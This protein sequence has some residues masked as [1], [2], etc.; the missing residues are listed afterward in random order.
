MNALERAIE[1]TK[2]AKKIA[3]EKEVNVVYYVPEGEWTYASVEI[4]T[5]DGEHYNIPLKS[6][7]IV[8]LDK[9]TVEFFK[10]IVEYEEGE[11]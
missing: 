11:E 3:K 5:E 10:N 6:R 7:G 9:E 2:K 4:V 8:M 1:K